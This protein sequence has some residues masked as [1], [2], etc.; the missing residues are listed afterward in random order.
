MERRGVL[1]CILRSK[2]GVHM[3]ALVL[4]ALVLF[5]CGREDWTAAVTPPDGA[6]EPVPL[7][8]VRG[9]RARGRMGVEMGGAPWVQY[10]HWG[11]R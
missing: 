10:K 11:W 2:S 6:E 1:G 3:V 5:T 7:M 4:L 8:P 9:R